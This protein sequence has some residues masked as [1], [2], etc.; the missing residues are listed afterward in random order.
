MRTPIVDGRSIDQFIPA[1][2][3]SM[4]YKNAIPQYKYAIHDGYAPY[5]FT[6]KGLVLYLPLWALKESS[7]KSVDAYQHTA[8]VTGALKRPDGRLFD[9]DDKIEIPDAASL[10]P[11]TGDWTMAMW[12]KMPANSA[13]MFLVDGYGGAA[14]DT[15]YY[16]DVLDTGYIRTSQQAGAAFVY[17][18]SDTV[19]DDNVWHLIAHTWVNSGDTLKVYIDDSDVTTGGGSGGGAVGDVQV[20]EDPIII[21]ASFIGTI[22]GMW[23]YN[24]ALSTGEVTHICNSTKW[25]YQ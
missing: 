24:R 10:S 16:F 8:T 2:L 19:V 20:G 11:R 5:G 1:N 22:D 9:G 13:R 6:T 25:R 12:L 23:F 3:R 7:F 15:G 17:K 4:F 21:G 14:P 18:D